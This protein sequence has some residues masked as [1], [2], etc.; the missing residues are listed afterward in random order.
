MVYSATLGWQEYVSCKLRDPTTDADGLL[1]LLQ[2]ERTCW[3]DSGCQKSQLVRV[4][5]M[6]P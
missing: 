5:I 4:E 3:T 1:V 6:F 2:D